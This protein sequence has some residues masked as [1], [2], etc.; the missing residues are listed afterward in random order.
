MRPATSTTDTSVLLRSRI[1]T[2][3]SSAAMTVAP[4]SAGSVTSGA[5]GRKLQGLKPGRCAA[6]ALS[7]TVPEDVNRA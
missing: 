5:I 4:A 1:A 7:F 3:P 2:A 6:V